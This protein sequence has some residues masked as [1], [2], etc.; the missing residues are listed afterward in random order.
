MGVLRR[1]GVLGGHHS[2]CE[3]REFMADVRGC[4][5]LISGKAF[6]KVAMLWARNCQ[7]RV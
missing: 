2:R 1:R 7:E 4:G 5:V 3:Q 6:G